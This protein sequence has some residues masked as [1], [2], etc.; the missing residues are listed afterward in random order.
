[1]RHI[2]ESVP[3]SGEPGDARCTVSTCGNIL[4]MLLRP[5]ELAACEARTEGRLLRSSLVP[6]GELLV[7]GNQKTR[8]S[9]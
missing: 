3:T 1:M 5:S 4:S 8:R 9:N 2:Y 7:A 6:R